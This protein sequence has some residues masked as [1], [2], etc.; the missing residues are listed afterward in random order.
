MEK[1][2]FV[3]VYLDDLLVISKSIYEDHVQKLDLVL[4]KLME[5]GLKVNLKKCTLAKTETEYLGYIITRK[6]IKPQPKKVEAIL[7]LGAPRIH[8]QLKIILDMV[9][10]YRDMWP[11]SSHILASLTADISSKNKK[12]FKW[13]DAM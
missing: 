6:G 11:K 3:R 1:L 13:T 7:N 9:Q 4:G 2:E 12:T 5:V 8:K 10:H